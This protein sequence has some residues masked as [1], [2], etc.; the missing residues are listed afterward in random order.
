MTI[1]EKAFIL[2][3]GYG[4]R[5]KPL[6]NT[7]PKPLVEIDG[8][9]LLDYTLDHFLDINIKEIIVNAHYLGDQ[10]ADWAAD[11]SVRFNLPIHVSHEPELLD[12]G[13]GIKKSLHYFEGEPFYVTVGDAFW[14]NAPG[15]N[16]LLTLAENWNP[17]IMDTLIILQDIKTMELT[18]GLGDYALGPDG[19][20]IRSLDKT[21]DY[22]FANIRINHP[23]AFDNTPDGAFS[24]LDCLDATEAKKRLFGL[25]HRGQWHHISTPEDLG[26]VNKD[27]EKNG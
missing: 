17:D 22:M 18:K 5:M 14:I 6:T 4:T 25:S 10:I 8:R 12:T 3:A 16:T 13:G 23:R 27:I 7:C 2:A 21:A 1:P 15:E 9:P 20:C 26:R 19:R 11:R 24:F